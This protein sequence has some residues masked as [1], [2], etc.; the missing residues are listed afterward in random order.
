VVVGH[1]KISI[2]L[3]IPALLGRRI[4]RGI[5]S[6]IGHFSCS[7][8]AARGI[9]W[10]KLGSTS[11]WNSNTRRRRR[12]SAPADI[13]SQEG[14][15]V[16]DVETTKFSEFVLQAGVFSFEITDAGEGGNGRGRG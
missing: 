7:T 11:K 3:G 14:R 15:F 10:T 16:V 12:R 13:R 6:L 8:P 9:L 2:A 1:H 4:I 5:D